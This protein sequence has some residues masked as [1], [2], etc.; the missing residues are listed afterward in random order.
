MHAKTAMNRF[1]I[2]GIMF[3]PA[4]LVERHEFYLSI[5]PQLAKWGY[6]TILWHFSDDEGFA[7]RLDSHPELA[8]PYAMSKVQTRRF[9]QAAAD[10]G[11]D[12]IPELESL[13]HSLAITGL[14]QYRHLF[15]GDPFDHNAICPSHPDTLPLIRTL[16]EEVAGLFP[17]QYFH[18]GLDE[19]DLRGCKRCALRARKRP[20]S[21]LL[22]EHAR[23]IHSSVTACGK[24]MMMWADPVEKH[25]QLLRELPRDIL[26]LHWHYAA[27]PAERIIP[28][29]DAGFEIVCV[30]K[31]C[32]GILQPDVD[33]MR[34]VNEMT[35]LAQQLCNRGCLGAIACWWEPARNLRDTYPLAAA[36]TAHLFARGMVRRHLSFTRSFAK[37]YFG[38]QNADAADALWRLHELVLTREEA[39]Y[40][41]PN[42]LGQIHEAIHASCTKDYNRLLQDAHQCYDLL[43]SGR[44]KVKAHKCEYDAYL[45]SARIIVTARTNALQLSRAAQ[46]YRRAALLHEHKAPREEI[47]GRLQEASTVVAGMSS[48][49]TELARAASKEWDRTRYSRDAKKDASSPRIRQRGDRMLLPELLRCSR[50]LRNLCRDFRAAMVIYRRGG[51]FPGGI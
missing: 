14:P 3:D 47:L 42:D 6:N 41:F 39:K 25:P 28:S 2:K 21:Y 34:N 24:R 44:R 15:D 38:L 37:E 33:A 27:V 13:G 4:R 19:V 8:S 11:I 51:P 48:S 30:P 32:G 36:Y 40:L 18:T 20:Q 45:L 31:M 7:L 12:V 29:V 16:I 9:I 35:A 1:Q 17:S 23:A 49:M 10:V 5:L 43:E 50:F 22:S 46:Y 26:L